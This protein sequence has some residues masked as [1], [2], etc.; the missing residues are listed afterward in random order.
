MNKIISMF[1]VLSVCLTMIV[2]ADE[3]NIADLIEPQTEN[4]E[5]LLKA[6]DIKESAEE[7]FS[8]E[9]ALELPESNDVTLYAAAE[10]IASGECGEN[11]GNITW[12]LD[13]NGTLTLSGSGNLA[14]YREDRDVPWYYYRY[15]IQNVNLDIVTETFCTA[16]H[17][18]AFKM[19]SNVS[20]I[21]IPEGVTEIP[22]SYD[23]FPET[24]QKLVLPSTYTGDLSDNMLIMK[25]CYLNIEVSEDNPIYSSADGTLFNKDKTKLVQYTRSAIEPNYV[26]PETVTDIDEAFCGNEYLQTLTISKNVEIVDVDIYNGNFSEHGMGNCA[27]DSQC[28]A[29][30]VDSEN[31]YFCS[32][33]GV[34]YNKDMSVIVWCPPLKTGS[35]CIPETVKIIAP[36]A[37]QSSKLSDIQIP[38]SV[39]VIGMCSFK[40]SHIESVRLP[41][42]IRT[43]HQSCLFNCPNLKKVYIEV[44]ENAEYSVQLFDS[45]N[46]KTAGPMGSGCDIE[47]CWTGKIPQNAFSSC[48]SLTKIVIPDSVT[49]IEDEAFFFCQNL[50]DIMIPE[51]VTEIGWYAF[52]FCR[53]LTEIAIPHSVTSIGTFA[54]DACSA[55]SKISIDR[56]EGIVKGAPWGAQNASITYLREMNIAPV[57][58]SYTYTGKAIMPAVSITEDRTDG[59]AS[60]KLKEYEDY[61]LAY[62]DNINAGTAEMKISFINGFA[63]LRSE[64][65]S[66]TITPKSIDSLAFAPIPNQEYT[67]RAVTPDIKI[68]DLER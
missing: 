36:S 52:G 34:L 23:L 58:K 33:D 21:I 62:S 2:C 28:S 49:L 19:L 5:T 3:N 66:F 18:H 16:M 20:E 68:T 4:T 48:R 44:S 54:F 57:T 10:I 51:S 41:D 67:S 60:Y 27:Y 30:Y 12:S 61:I 63:K 55:L 1:L 17:C 8:T 31:P 13:Y 56:A 40:E 6:S 11:G 46:L 64:K 50:T 29:V 39:K 65:Q 22:Q 35:F 42:S 32:V 25:M 59:T 14:N 9:E 47:F 53:S 15:Q 45:Y 24:L 26:V 7:E 37:F 43:I 38:E